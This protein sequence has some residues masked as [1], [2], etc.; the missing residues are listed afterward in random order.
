MSN[1]PEEAVPLNVRG[2]DKAPEIVTTTTY[3]FPYMKKPKKKSLSQRIYDREKGKF[4]GRTPENWGK[5]EY[6]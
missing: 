2:K 6:L 4:F 5:Y 3:E 1:Q